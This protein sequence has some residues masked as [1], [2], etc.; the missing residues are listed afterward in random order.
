MEQIVFEAASGRLAER[1]VRVG[2]PL[3]QAL[4]A[5]GAAAAGRRSSCPTAS[6]VPS[7]LQAAGGVSQFHF[8][9][10][11]LS[12]A[13]QVKVGPPLALESTFAANPDP[14]ESDPA[15][16]D[17]A[18]LAE[19]VPGW[20]FAYLTNWKDLTGN[21][22]S[23]SRRGE[24][25]RPLLYGVL[26][27]LIVESILAWKFGH[28]APANVSRRM[29]TR[30]RRDGLAAPPTGRSTG[31]RTGAGRR[32]DHA[33]RSGSSNR[34]PQGVTLLVVLGCAAL[35]VWLYRREGPARSPYKMR[36][37]R[38][39]DL[40]GPAG[41]L[42][43]L[44]GGAL[45]RADGPAVLRGHGRRLG[46]PAGR[47]PVRQPQDQ[48]ARPSELAEARRARPE[49]EPAGRRRR[50]GSCK[51]DGKVLREL[52][53]QNKVR[54][55]LVSTAAAA[56]RRDRQARRRRAGAREAQEGRGRAAARRGSGDGRPPGPHRA[57]RRSPVGDRP[58]LTDGQ[59]TDGES[60]R[61]G[62]RV[63]RAQGRA[64]L[65]RSAWATPSRPATSS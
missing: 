29:R 27:L 43:A 55:Y 33:L 57:P 19:A 64:A 42:H 48:G 3:D 56:A 32:G 47:R 1:N 23:V 45:G 40:A 2:Q 16:L 59:T 7:K 58:A 31:R 49:A 30:R 13:Y 63:R 8:E 18:G 44:R 14:A 4:P 50:A 6:R 65:S 15:K 61:Q 22:T 5:S 11:E 46:Q 41:R 9:E 39:A 28:H 26:V 52:Q 10:T 25:H 34:W 62:R 20:N 51:D 17:R 60:A 21:A 35:I 37:A 38:A 53:K 24:L 36:L 54:L 12:G